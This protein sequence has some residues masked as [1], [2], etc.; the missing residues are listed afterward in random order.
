MRM[1][2]VICSHRELSVNS[3]LNFICEH[4]VFN[5][6]ESINLITIREKVTTQP[7]CYLLSEV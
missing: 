7:M 4:A 6:L 1:G 2:K 5:C 3:V